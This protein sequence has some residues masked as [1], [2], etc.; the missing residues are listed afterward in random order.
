MDNDA[1]RRL[2]RSVIQSEANVTGNID[3]GE[4]QYQTPHAFGSKKKREKT[5]HANGHKD[6][7]V[8][9]YKRVKKNSKHIAQLY[10]TDIVLSSTL[11]DLKIFIDNNDRMYKAIKVPILKQLNNLIKK[12]RFTIAHALKPFLYFVE[13]GAIRY[14]KK[15][16]GQ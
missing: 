5:G 15:Q 16:G 2:I 10:E 14:A 4:G 6:P 8:F 1:L 7:E 12:D 3:G 13:Q 11:Q 9:D